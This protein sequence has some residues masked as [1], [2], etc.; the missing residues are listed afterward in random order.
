MPSQVV[1]VCEKREKHMYAFVAKYIAP[2]AV[3]AALLLAVD[4]SRAEDYAVPAEKILLPD[5]GGRACWRKV[6]GGKRPI[7]HLR[8]VAPEKFVVFF[9]RA[10]DHV[11][12][13][14]RAPEASSYK[15]V[16]EIKRRGDKR[17]FVAS[18]D[19]I[20][21]KTANCSI[22]C[23]GVTGLIEKSPPTGRSEISFLDACDKRSRA[24][25]K[26]GDDNEEYGLEPAPMARC[27]TL[28]KKY[29]GEM[30]DGSTRR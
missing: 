12:G 4:A 9:L 1:P 27:R 7:K 28:E 5:P 17:A 8:Q 24:R 18:G 20:E 6:Y 23:G 19:C 21:D 22:G 25:L 11:D 14:D 2:V 30:P 10:S 29:L 16:A 15:F 13:D 3:P 26:F